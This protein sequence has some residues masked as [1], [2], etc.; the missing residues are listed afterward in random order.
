L[1]GAIAPVSSRRRPMMRGL[2]ERVCGVA[3]CA[4]AIEEVLA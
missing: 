1:P 4:Q 2:S 3:Q